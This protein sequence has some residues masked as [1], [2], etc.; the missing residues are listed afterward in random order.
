MRNKST[1][2]WFA[3]DSDSK[4][5]GGYNVYKHKPQFVTEDAGGVY[6]SSTGPLLDCLCATM[7]R[8]MGMPVLKP[9]ECARVRLT[10]EKV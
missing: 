3:R 5:A 6:V 10:M 1:V 2:V 4:D 9:G 8:G 7:W